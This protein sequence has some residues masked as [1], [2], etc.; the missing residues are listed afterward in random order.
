MSFKLTVA[1]QINDP[2]F[3]KSKDIACQLEQQH[4][5][6]V[7]VTVL[8]FFETQ[9]ILYLKKIAN[10]LKGVFYSHEEKNPLIFLDGEKYIGDAH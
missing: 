7:Q 1:G 4:P 6:R 5:E 9:W 2:M 3:H 10:E 8:Q